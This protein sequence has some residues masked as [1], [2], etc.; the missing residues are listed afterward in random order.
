TWVDNICEQI[1]DVRPI[2]P[3]KIGTNVRP[4]TVKRMTLLA[5]SAE[6]GTAQ[7]RIGRLLGFLG[8]QLTIVRDERSLVGRGGADLSPSIIEH[9]INLIVVKIVKLTNQVG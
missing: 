2:R 1:F 7:I 4:H 5:S 6:N 9:L 3:C 8:E